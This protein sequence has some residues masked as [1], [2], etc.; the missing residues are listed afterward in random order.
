M[1]WPPTKQQP[2]GLRK[3]DEWR[4]GSG[5]G[6]WDGSRV[7]AVALPV[8]NERLSRQWQ[9]QRQRQHSGDSDSTR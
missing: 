4:E 8:R 7:A 9:Q 1:V 6:E 3:P 2:S 5:G